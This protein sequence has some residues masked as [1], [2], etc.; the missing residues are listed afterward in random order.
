MPATEAGVGFAIVPISVALA[1]TTGTEVLTESADNLALL[2]SAST[3]LLEIETTGFIDQATNQ[4][5]VQG[6]AEAVLTP[7]EN[8]A[9][10]LDNKGDGEIAGN[11]TEDATLL[12]RTYYRVVQ[13]V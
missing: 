5:R 12:V 11:A 1:F 7:V 6:M 9:I 8:T 2:Y 10:D 4:N 13:V 3:E